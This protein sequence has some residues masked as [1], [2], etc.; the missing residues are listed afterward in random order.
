LF[1]RLLYAHSYAARGGS[2][3]HFPA[4]LLTPAVRQEAHPSFTP[5]AK[6]AGRGSSTLVLE[7]RNGKGRGFQRG[8]EEE[9][10]EVEGKEWRQGG[11]KETKEEKIVHLQEVGLLRRVKTGDQGS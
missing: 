8:K 11:K 3:L 7:P 2:G 5:R 4:A 10:N 1:T 9:G 6:H